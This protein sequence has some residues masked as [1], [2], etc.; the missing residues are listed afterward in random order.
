MRPEIGA[1][2]MIGEHLDLL[3]YRRDE[4]VGLSAMPHAFADRVDP[5]IVDRVHLV[6]DHDR[7]QP[8]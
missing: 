5:W 6:L 1:G 2:Y 3:P 8:P 4:A 7:A